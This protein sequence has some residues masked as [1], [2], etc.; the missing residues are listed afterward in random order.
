M[1]KKMKVCQK[2]IYRNEKGDAYCGV[3]SL[4]GDDS[5]DALRDLLEMLEGLDFDDDDDE[6][7]GYDDDDDYDDDDE[8]EREVAPS[9]ATLARV[10]D[11][12]LRNW[13]SAAA[14]STYQKHGIILTNTENCSNEHKEG[15]LY[16]VH[17]FMSHKAKEKVKY[18]FLDLADSHTVTRPYD[19]AL[20]DLEFVVSVLRRVNEAYPI[21]YLLILGDRDAIASARWENG[22]CDSDKY[23]DSDVPYVFLE[24]R[25]LFDG[26]PASCSIRVGRV[27]AA[28]STGFLTAKSYLENVIKLHKTRRDLNTL[29]LSAEEWGNVTRHVFSGLSPYAYTCPPY[30][31]VEG[32]GDY[33]I[34]RDYPY[35]L[36]CFNLHGSPVHNTWV[37]GSG[38][39]GINPSSLPTSPNKLYVLGSEACYGAKPVIKKTAS[40]SMLITA[41]RNRCLGFLGSTQI[42]YGI[43]DSMLASG[44]KPMCADVMVGKFADMVYDGYCLGD[45]YIE[46]WRAVSSSYGRDLE[47]VKTL[48]SFALYGDP[49]AILAERGDVRIAKTVATKLRKPEVDISAKMEKIDPKRIPILA[50]NS[51]VRNN[52]SENYTLTPSVYRVSSEVNSSTILISYTHKAPKEYRATY[53][54]TENNINNVLHVYFSE[55][56]RVIRAYASK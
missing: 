1:E 48:C 50:V 8:P 10:S 42:A 11:T 39:A 5:I 46:A 27:P 7:D 16:S 2:C 44:C 3:C 45:A 24:T 20:N 43:H 6:Y 26:K 37:S 36:L 12:W 18:C 35:D 32:V 31:F 15:F 19:V 55:D 28:A 53:T 51:F 4:K 23:V 54:K 29:T 22:A 33:N 9:P 49:T 30:S 14:D 47:N 52:I 56:G 25:S 40:Q 41:L 38:T 34:S 17:R 21:E 13:I